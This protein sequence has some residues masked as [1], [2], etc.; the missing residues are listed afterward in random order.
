MCTVKAQT[1]LVH[2]SRRKAISLTQYNIAKAF[3]SP[4]DAQLLWVMGGCNSRA[5]RLFLVALDGVE[6]GRLDEGA[7]SF[8]SGTKEASWER[9]VSDRGIIWDLY[10]G[11]Q[12]EEKSRAVAQ[13]APQTNPLST[14]LTH[15]E[16]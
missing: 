16:P 11:R 3:H 7:Q 15:S 2:W 9:R 4:T 13:R 12:R 6:V 8:G 10:R 5:W 1:T 14:N